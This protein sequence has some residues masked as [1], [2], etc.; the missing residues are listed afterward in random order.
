MTAAIL[1]LSIADYE[2]MENLGAV[3]GAHMLHPLVELGNP[4]VVAS[5]GPQGSGKSTLASAALEKLSEFFARHARIVRNP[6]SK[7]TVIDTPTQTRAFRFY[8]F[9]TATVEKG[10]MKDDFWFLPRGERMRSEPCYK[11]GIDILEHPPISH[12]RAA[13]VVVL[14]SKRMDDDSCK[15]SD[16]AFYFPRMANGIA[17]REVRGLTSFQGQFQCDH[18]R[19][20]QILSEMLRIKDKVVQRPSEK[21]YAVTFVLGND[22]P[23]FREAFSDFVKAV[24][25]G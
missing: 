12:L 17:G 6:D 10:D 15:F 1:R 19:T 16:P 8:D 22:R 24:G 3:F 20:P 5:Y 9:G 18:P 11:I 4:L 23:E 2:Q 13:D 7:W 25:L 21:A 14:T